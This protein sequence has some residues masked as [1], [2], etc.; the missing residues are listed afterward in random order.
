[1]HDFREWMLK[2]RGVT[3]ATLNSYRPVLAGLLNAVEGDVGRLRPANIRTF[4]MQWGKDH[5]R[6]STAGATGAIRMFL[7]YLAIEGKVTNQCI[8]SRTYDIL[9]A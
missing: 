1:L 7:R 2:H 4:V 8:S 6:S 3:E 9:T 5:A